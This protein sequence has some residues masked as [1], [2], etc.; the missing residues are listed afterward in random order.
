MT[1]NVSA[2]TFST[3]VGQPAQ[4]TIT[5]THAHAGA[6]TATLSGTN[7]SDFSLSSTTP[8]ANSV[9]EGTQSLVITFSPSCNGTR[10]AQLTLHS[11]NG[12][13]DVVINL[14]GEGILNAQTITWDE[15][16]DTKM[17]V[18]TT[19]SISATATSGL[20]VTYTSS[21]PDVLSVEGNMLT[22]N[23]VGSAIITATQAGDCTFAPQS[24]TKEFTIN[25]KAT[26][27]FWLNNNPDQTEADL[28][29][30]ESI[31]IY[32]ENTDA[33]LSAE[34]D[35]NIFSYTLQ[36]NL[37][38][39]TTKNAAENATFTLSQPE[40]ATLSA[41]KRT[42]TFHITKYANSITWK[43]GDN[44]GTSHTLNYDGGVYVSYQ[45]ANNNLEQTPI[46]VTQTAGN[47][48][49]TYYDD[50]KAIYA[51]HYNGTATWHVSQAEDYKYLAAETT[52]SVTVAPLT[53]TCYAVE[54]AAQH[55]IG[56]YSNKDGIEYTLNGI[57]ETL[58]IEVW[59][60][61]AATDAITIYGYNSNNSETEIAKYSTGSLSTSAQPKTETLSEDIVKIKVKAGG[62]LDKHFKNLY[63]TRKQ[64]LTPSATSLTIPAIKVGNRDSVAFALS[65]STCADAIKLASSNPHFKLSQNEISA[66]NG[67]GEDTIKI[68]YSS[69]RFGQE[70]SVITI[71]TPYQNTTL[72]VSGSTEKKEQ[73]LSW[74]DP[75]EQID[76]PTISS[77][78]VIKN[79]VT[80]SVDG[81]VV[82]Y[83][84]SD[85]SVIAVETDG[86]TLRALKAGEATITAHHDGNEEWAEAS[87]SKTFHVTEKQVQHIV[88]D[89]N[90][91]RLYTDGGAITLTA[92][93][94]TE[95]AEGNWSF[96]A[97]RTAQ[98]S[99]A[100]ADNN[101][102][103]VSGNTLTIN[104]IG[105]TTI[106]ATV[107]G[108]D[109]YEAAS[110]TLPVQVSRATAGCLDY[111]VATDCPEKIEFFQKNLNKIEKTFTIDRN[112]GIPYKLVFQH[113]GE[114]WLLSYS[115][116][117]EVRE[118]TDGGQT[119]SDVLISVT[120]VVG[121]YQVA[122]TT[123]SRNA[124]HIR[125]TR[126]GNSTGYHYISHVEIEPARF[127]ES[128][129]TVIDFGSIEVGS[130][131]QRE[132]TIA[133]SDIKSSLVLS[134]QDAENEES[135]PP[136]NALE[137]LTLSTTTIGECGTWGTNDP[138]TISF[139][140]NATQVGNFRSFVV[141]KD[142]VSGSYHSIPVV[143]EVKPNSHFTFTGNQGA[144]TEWGDDSNW[145]GGVRPSENDDVIIASDVIVTGEVAVAGL[146][147][148]PGNTL[149]IKVQGDL[150]IGDNSSAALSSYG[151]L[152]IEN[153]GKVTL[154]N[155]KLLVN[156]FGIE[157]QLG[158]ADTPPVSGQ[159]SNPSN[160]SIR[161]ET[162]FELTLD[163][164]VC[165][166][167]W[168]EFTVPFLVDAQNG[169][170]RVEGNDIK[171]ITFGTH[172]IIMDHH[173]DLQ[174]RG[175]YSWKAFRGIMTPNVGYT[176]TV[177]DEHNTF[178]FYK[179]KGS[180]LANTTSHPLQ[181]S[182]GDDTRRG[183]N[184]LGNGTL[185]YASVDMAGLDKV[186]IY[187]HTNNAYY[188]IFA[189]RQTFAIGS[190]FFVQAKQNGDIRYIPATSVPQ[191]LRAPKNIETFDCQEVTL[192]LLH[193]DRV[194]D[195]LYF[196]AT[197]TALSTYQIGHDL[198]KI[199]DLTQSR[200]A[201]L[202]SVAYGLNLCDVELPATT[203]E[204]VFDLHFFAPQADEY[205]LNIDN[206]PANA[207]VYLL[208]DGEVIAN[209]S[210]DD[211]TLTLPQGVTD[212]YELLLKAAPQVTTDINAVSSTMEAEKVL[213]NGQLYILYHGQVFDASGHRI[214]Q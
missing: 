20:D 27:I 75:W 162:Y 4:Q 149:T 33:S 91:T 115:G 96:N 214:N 106:T 67:A 7:A 79:P 52:I 108:N 65:W 29:V 100:S 192:Q 166:F 130:T 122:T 196:S 51:S 109:T 120:P 72:T 167:G 187:D 110:T 53:T 39:I 173:E 205:T 80:S 35:K 98:L 10:T 2:V 101:I 209:L 195:R 184:G 78:R 153:G 127:I 5:I 59:K 176:I 157:A 207:T 48:I 144:S 97:E 169:V 212:T 15:P 12:L 81:W 183:W 150:T 140:P 71:Y 64:L 58:S 131:E 43:F 85:P 77:G 93:V 163:Q 62:T 170:F 1:A 103:S 117:I 40:T 189:K 132:F 198:L 168:Y 178:R 45:S 11:N 138:I 76:K 156:D 16:I 204:T 181:V 68:F 47:D 84:S 142:P 114:K 116:P 188:A 18:G 99:Y 139:T 123:L 199:G 113:S 70:S 105:S 107:P 90:L 147:I 175:Q 119:W 194:I 22:A 186:Q 14:T 126:P 197:D 24:I 146:T 57:G 83:T 171:P 9:S 129:N 74:V 159:I 151:N 92:Q 172:Y 148:N 177:D 17:M 128:P 118:S 160:L 49:A 154:G 37:L 125:F 112:T 44:I 193:S 133:Y 155:G 104:G 82:T 203:D 36:D 66:T 55:S 38:T 69:D 61:T 60:E 28:K 121:N 191:P 41:A 174:A 165:T 56:W 95:D 182:N 185:Q 54:D 87:T 179:T 21:N 201:R 34:Y 30:E 211:Y 152:I 136:S 190:A 102:V 137:P 50:Q 23:K 88:W 8:V 164:P 25:A 26:P 46:S 89:Q 145:S 141:I 6:I 213:H 42:F 161:G 134:I 180:N 200:V 73:T 158:N 124:T 206:Q 202:W 32:I 19:R 210:A 111:F 13:S 135:A 31:T 3:P 94:Y 143:A 208:R 63:I 86:I